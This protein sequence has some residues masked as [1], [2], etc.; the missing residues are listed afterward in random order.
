[1]ASLSKRLGVPLITLYL[2][3]GAIFGGLC[4]G[5]GIAAPPAVQSVTAALHNACLA[6]ITVAAGCELDPE[7]LRSNARTIRATVVALCVSAPLVVGGAYLVL[8]PRA[9]TA[10]DAALQA[11]V[12]LFCGVIAIARS[13]SSAIA[14]V[15]EA[16]SDGPFTQTVLGV[17]MLAAPSSAHNWMHGLR[18]RANYDAGK[19][20]TTQPCR[21]RTQFSHPHVNVN[22]GQEFMAEWMTG[23]GGDVIFLMLKAEDEPSLTQFHPN[24]FNAYLREAP[25]EAYARYNG[26][27]VSRSAAQT[28]A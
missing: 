9:T 20:S 10:D 17:T 25:P 1:M 15:S 16:R 2:I 22:A 21:A 24:V 11:V 12:A 6:L 5:L 14:V 7:A 26:S 13:P 3:A 23:H 27:R 4:T 18:S 19:A 8:L 28:P